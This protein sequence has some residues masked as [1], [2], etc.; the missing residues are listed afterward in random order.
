MAAAEETFPGGKERGR[1]RTF[2]AYTQPQTLII[3]CKLR[4]RICFSGAAPFMTDGGHVCLTG[5][6]IDTC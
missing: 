1:E 6:L 4:N 5:G 2:S 3:F